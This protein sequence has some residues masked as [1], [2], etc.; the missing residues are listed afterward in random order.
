MITEGDN[1]GLIL[2][3]LRWTKPG[4]PVVGPFTLSLREQRIGIV[5]RNGSGK[6]TFARLVSGLIEPASGCAKAF[7]VDMW[8]DR[9]GAISAVGVL[10]Q[11]PD[12]QIIF[13]TV[14]EEI[15]FGLTQLGQSKK[16]A[17]ARA[18][19]ALARFQKEHWAARS[20]HTLSGGQRHLVCLM[21]VLAMAPKLIILDEPYAGLDIPTRRAMAAYLGALDQQIIHITHEPD[22]LGGYDRVLW[23]D[24]G[25]VRMDGAPDVV[26]P[27]YLTAMEAA[28]AGSDLTD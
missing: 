20:I 1:T 28:D 14:E 15:A 3:D 13:P 16:D 12:H 5:G 27:A 2:K 24:E 8:R 17:R 11:N 9:K 22:V 18:L 23:I 19:A 10:F 7:G 6:S 21:A 4:A 26:L 25:V